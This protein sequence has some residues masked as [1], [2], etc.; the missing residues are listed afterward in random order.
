MVHSPRRERLLSTP[1][2]RALLHGSEDLFLRFG[3]MF[4]ETIDAL[5]QELDVFL[6]R[7]LKIKSACD[8][9]LL[10]RRRSI[11]DRHIDDEVITLAGARCGALSA[12]SQ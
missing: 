5:L 2:F 8:R 1:T 12:I 10:A 9:G 11:W 4:F 6:G 7:S 3:E